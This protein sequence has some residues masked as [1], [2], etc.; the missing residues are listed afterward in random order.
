MFVTAG[1]FGIT[2]LMISIT[3]LITGL[4]YIARNTRDRLESIAFALVMSF[5]TTPGIGFLREWSMG[6]MDNKESAV[7]GL[8]LFV[9][10]VV[11]TF[12]VFVFDRCRLQVTYGAKSVDN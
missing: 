7:S 6:S 2:N 12:I 1:P 3:L 11:V 9:S 4:A 8:F 10:W 5:I